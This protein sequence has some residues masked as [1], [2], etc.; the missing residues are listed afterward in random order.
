VLQQPPLQHQTQRQVG[1]ASIAVYDRSSHPFYLGIIPA[2]RGR[3]CKLRS[4]LPADRN[5]ERC[6]SLAHEG[7]NAITISDDSSAACAAP[8]MRAERAAARWMRESKAVLALALPAILANSFQEATNLTSQVFAGRLGVKTLAAISVANTVSLWEPPP[9]KKKSLITA[10]A[11][12]CMHN[13]QLRPTS[14]PPHC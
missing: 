10:T 9:C 1:S 6:S 8:C 2:R 13:V 3:L 5:S 12:W 7:N 14:G 4:M 11:L